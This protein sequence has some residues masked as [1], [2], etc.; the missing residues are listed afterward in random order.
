MDKKDILR[1]ANDPRFISGIYNYCDRWCERCVFTSRCLTYAMEKEDFE[2][3]EA[4]DLNNKAFWDKLQLIFQQTIEMIKELAM[5][6]GIDL[7]SLDMESTDEEFSQR[8]DKAKDHELS[9]SARYYSKI[10]D[11]WFESGY[12]LLEQRQNEL[13]TILE[14]GISGAEPYTVADEIIDSVEVIRWYQHQIYVKLMRAL[15]GDELADIQEEDNALQKDSD[16]SALVALIAIDRSIG[17]WG[18]LQDHFPEKTNSILDILL[19][20]D[21]LRRKIE[22]VF[23]DARNF[24][25]PGFDDSN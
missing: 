1:M 24:K 12:P 6:S 22:Q 2:D 25:R 19:H 18:R 8:Q 13:N 20:L 7:N 9:L 21:R 15:R 3:I 11:R 10:V 17:A 23:P 14:L 4:R 5:E 16:G